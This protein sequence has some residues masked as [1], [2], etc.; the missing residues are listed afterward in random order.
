MTASNLRILVIGSGGREHAIARKLLASPAVSEVYCAPGNP[1]MVATG[2]K[3]VPLGELAFDQLI[4][5]AKKQ[6]ISWT[7][8]GP[9]DAL[10]AGIVDREYYH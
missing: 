5:F 1:G 2:I 6:N 9:E 7:F 3:L 4:E 10:V 8:V